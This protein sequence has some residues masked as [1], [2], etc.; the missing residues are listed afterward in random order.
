MNSSRVPKRSMT[1]ISIANASKQYITGQT[2]SRNRYLSRIRIRARVGK[3]PRRREKKARAPSVLQLIHGAG[4]ALGVGHEIQDAEDV[5]GAFA[6]VGLHALVVEPGQFMEV[7]G[8]LAAAQNVGDHPWRAIQGEKVTA[9]H[10]TADFRMMV[11]DHGHQ[12]RALTVEKTKLVRNAGEN[13]FKR[14]RVFGPVQKLQNLL[15]DVVEHM[16]R[17]Y[18]EVVVV[19][20]DP[21]QRLIEQQQRAPGLIPPQRR[22]IHALA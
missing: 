12:P 17:Q 2:N 11:H 14:Y 22:V 13:P 16:T 19:E 8:L 6:A 3:P 5:A 4:D 18:G 7:D 9:I 10:R 20:R 15:F 1:I 21:F